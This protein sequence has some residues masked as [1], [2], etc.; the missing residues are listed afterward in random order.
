MKVCSR[1]MRI[2]KAVLIAISLGLLFANWMEISGAY[3]NILMDKL[4]RGDRR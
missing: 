1:K 4:G 2:L 3:I